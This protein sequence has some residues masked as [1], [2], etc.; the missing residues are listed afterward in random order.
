MA[1]LQLVSRVLAEAI[2][3]TPFDVSYR[4]RLLRE[5]GL[6]PESKRG[7]GATPVGVGEAAQILIGCLVSDSP[8]RVTAGVKLYSELRQ[9]LVFLAG[10]YTTKLNK[11][12]PECFRDSLAGTLTFLLELCL[13][14]KGRNSVGAAVKAIQVKR[15]SRAYR[16]PV[17]QLDV[18]VQRQNQPLLFSVVYLPKGAIKGDVEWAQGLTYSSS[19]EPPVAAMQVTAAVG[20]TVLPVLGEVLSEAGEQAPDRADVLDWSE[21]QLVA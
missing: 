18:F 1:S 8:A 12:L 21:L 20:G 7:R 15:I 6:L 3:W 11:K 5:A 14:P 4:A 13:S 9:G 19:R 17:A 10:G 2:G 16:M